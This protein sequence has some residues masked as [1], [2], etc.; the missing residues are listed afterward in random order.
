M[1]FHLKKIC[2]LKKEKTEAVFAVAPSFKKEKIFRS[3]EVYCMWLASWEVELFFAFGDW[4]LV[5]VILKSGKGF[6]T[7]SESDELSRG[8]CFHNV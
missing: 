3:I 4:V 8:E 7:D 2:Y 1:V 6:R 5:T